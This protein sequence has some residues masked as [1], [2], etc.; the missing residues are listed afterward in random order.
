M[1][2]KVKTIM[3]K[4]LTEWLFKDFGLLIDEPS[5]DEIEISLEEYEEPQEELDS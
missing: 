3:A 5:S 2:E 4:M 1:G